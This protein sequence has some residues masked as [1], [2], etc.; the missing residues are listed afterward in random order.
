MVGSERGSQGLEKSFRYPVFSFDPGRSQKEKI[1]LDE[2]QILE[3]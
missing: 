3:T 1:E 2:L